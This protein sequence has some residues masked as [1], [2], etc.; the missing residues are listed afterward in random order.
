LTRR[1]RWKDAR[2][3]ERFTAEQIVGLLHEAGAAGNAREVYRK[4]WTAET[5][6]HRCRAQYGKMQWAEVTRPKQL[7]EE[8]RRVEQLGR[9]LA[10]GSAM[11]TE[12]SG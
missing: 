3:R 12:V 7:E 2:K 6:L 10:L 9:E 5:T 4:R 11:R 8:N 1:G